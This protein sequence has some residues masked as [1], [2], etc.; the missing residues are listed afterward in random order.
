MHKSTRAVR[1]NKLVHILLT[2]LFMYS[3]DIVHKG[4]L[5]SADGS[6]YERRAGGIH[7][8]ADSYCPSHPSVRHICCTPLISPARSIIQFKAFMFLRSVGN[9]PVCNFKRWKLQFM[10][11]TVF[12][13]MWRHVGNINP[14]QISAA[15]CVSVWIPLVVRSGFHIG[16]VQMQLFRCCFM[17]NWTV[18]S[19]RR[20]KK[21]KRNLST[22]S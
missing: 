8:V 7:G 19:E 14:E 1:S 12:W 18:T 3:D 20:E 10:L 13:Y 17:L 9:C 4:F 2:N 5:L 15:V 16:F 6:R 22:S 21:A 11:P